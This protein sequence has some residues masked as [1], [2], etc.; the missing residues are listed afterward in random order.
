MQELIKLAEQGDRVV[1]FV[2]CGLVIW[3]LVKKMEQREALA[4]L[5]QQEHNKML[6][7][8]ASTNQTVIKENTVAFLKVNETMV[9]LIETHENKK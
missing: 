9:K 5:Q 2:L 6:T 3:W 8:I 4:L 1:L 7:E